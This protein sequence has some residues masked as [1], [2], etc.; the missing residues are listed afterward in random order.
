MKLSLERSGDV[1][2][3]DGVKS[4]VYEGEPDRLQSCRKLDVLARR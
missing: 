2:S 3:I 4:N 1:T